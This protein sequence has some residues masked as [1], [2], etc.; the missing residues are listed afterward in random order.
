[1]PS[2]VEGCDRQGVT[3]R[4]LHRRALSVTKAGGLLDV[5]LMGITLASS[6]ER[7]GA[8]AVPACAS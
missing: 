4:G 3:G 1:M 6:I 5:T 2:S 7:L 8:G